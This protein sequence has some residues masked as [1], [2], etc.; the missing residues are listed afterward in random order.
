MYI[1]YR[2]KPPSIK[3]QYKIKPN[4][5]K[6]YDRCWHAYDRPRSKCHWWFIITMGFPYAERWHRNWRDKYKCLHQSPNNNSLSFLL[7]LA[8]THIHTHT[9]THSLSLFLSIFLSFSL[10]LSLSHTHIHT[11]THTHSL[12]LFARASLKVLDMANCMG[13]CVYMRVPVS[14]FLH[15]RIGPCTNQGCYTS[16]ISGIGHCQCHTFGKSVQFSITC[17]FPFHFRFY[18]AFISWQL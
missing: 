17:C 8:H 18:V 9:H 12:S 2:Y 13:A 11:H 10:S 1:Y 3:E 7:S 4:K 16:S 15:Y 6:Y 14:M 5:Y